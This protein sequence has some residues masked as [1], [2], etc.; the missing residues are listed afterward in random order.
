[1]NETP[2]GTLTPVDTARRLILDGVPRIRSG[3]RVGL[4]AAAGRI[5]ASDLRAEIDVP[6]FANSAM[7]GYAL[8]A[9]DARQ[10]PVTLPVKLRIA[11]GQDGG[12]LPTGEAARIF[13]GAM[14][15]AGADAVVIQ[16]N[17]RAGAGAVTLLQPAAPGQHVRSAGDA[18][19]RGEPLFPAGH[20]LLPQD[21]GMAG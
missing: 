20:R 6:P 10:T 21:V 4:T 17:C 12:S 11:A 18:M 2:G 8:R 16:E 1:M 5:L 14:M 7:D 13:T 9:A 15:P 3:K 19:R